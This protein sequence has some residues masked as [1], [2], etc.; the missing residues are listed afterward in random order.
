[1]KDDG[2]GLLSDR[3]IKHQVIFHIQ[4]KATTTTTATTST[5]FIYI[6]VELDVFYTL[7]FSYK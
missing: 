3:D 6:S 5:P 7:L 4:S 2:G 1:M